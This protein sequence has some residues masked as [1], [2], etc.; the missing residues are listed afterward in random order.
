[1][2]TVVVVPKTTHEDNG[3]GNVNSAGPR[4]YGPLGSWGADDVARPL[5]VVE[6]TVGLG[7]PSGS[8][9]TCASFCHPRLC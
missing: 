3:R 7:R 6:D 8:A 4:R 1:M 2:V 5:D 9:C